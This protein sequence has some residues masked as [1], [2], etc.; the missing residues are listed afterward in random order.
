MNRAYIVSI[1]VG[2]VLVIAFFMYTRSSTMETFTGPD[3][4]VGAGGSNL[5]L[6]AG[7]SNLSP[8]L[9][10]AT[11]PQ[12]NNIVMYNE[13]FDP[14]SILS[15]SKWACDI[16]SSGNMSFMLTGSIDY[17]D[18][19]QTST[20]QLVGPSSSSFTTASDFRL[21]S[22][23]VALYGLI[24]TL[25]ALPVIVFIMHAETSYPNTPNMIEISFNAP[26][27]PAD[28]THINVMMD[29]GQVHASWLIPT[30]TLLTRQKNLYTF[31]YDNSLQSATF[32]IGTSAPYTYTLPAPVTPGSSNLTPGSSNLTPPPRAPIILGN[33]S[34]AVNNNKN[35]DMG[36]YAFV[37]YSVALS[38]SDQ[39]VLY[40][41]FTQQGSGLAL[42]IQEQLN[43]ASS[44][45]SIK[46]Q[47]TS[48]LSMYENA[49]NICQSSLAAASVSNVFKNPWQINLD[50]ANGASASLADMYKCSPL[51]VKKYGDGSSN[52][53]ILTNPAASNADY[54]QVPAK[55]F[56]VSYP[57][58]T[59]STIASLGL[60]ALANIANPTIT[61]TPA[62][63][64]AAAAAAAPTQGSISIS[65][66]AFLQYMQ[67]VTSNNSASTAPTASNPSLAVPATSN[68]DLQSVYS[69]LSQAATHD[70]TT[71]PLS[72]V[73]LASANPQAV[74]VTPA[75]AYL[76]NSSMFWV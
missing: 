31:V 75:P 34:M 37:Y 38:T 25:T 44:L 16:P 56:V 3:P 73:G 1:L 20:V 62:V 53:G 13:V 10:L 59:P 36:L 48:N 66:A 51:A 72:S 5:Q 27:D 7:G 70:K 54:P 26:T 29:V 17:S 18:G 21:S 42:Y 65:D 33:S 52:S 61:S 43:A 55:R 2:F 64:T 46:G 22:F 47:F 74:A 68:V 19:L 24:N 6:P 60:G 15:G 71:T 28:T 58:N 39:V 40:N 14:K 57:P 4:A 50:Q 76:D 49:L 9:T 23:T 35:L 67:S 45:A 69:V 41:Y 12:T 30:S 8:S 32:Y 11:M 63:G